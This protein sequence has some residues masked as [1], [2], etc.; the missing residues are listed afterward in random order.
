MATAASFGGPP[1]LTA[2]AA[3]LWGA[4][5]IPDSGQFSAL[6]AD[7]APPEYA[8]SLLTLQTALGFLLSALTVQAL[9]YVAG[10]IG[11]PLALAAL[12]PGPLLGAEAMRRLIRLQD[13]K[14]V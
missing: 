4:A 2:T 6:V 5:I 1:L 10:M 13:G 9:P 7:A 11:W 3:L 8:G 12:A 14:Q